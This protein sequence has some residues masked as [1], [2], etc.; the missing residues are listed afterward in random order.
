[1]DKNQINE[2]IWGNFDKRILE[3]QVPFYAVDWYSKKITEEAI[4]L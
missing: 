1:M 2:I 4:F 3:K